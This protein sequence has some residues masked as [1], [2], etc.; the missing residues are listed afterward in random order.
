MRHRRATINESFGAWE[1]LYINSGCPVRGE[2][3]VHFQFYCEDFHSK[4][5]Q[6]RGYAS[7]A[8]KAVLAQGFENG[9]HRAYAE[10]DPR[11][12]CS[13]ALLEKCGFHREALLRQNVWFQKDPSGNPIWQN[14]YVYALLSTDQ[15]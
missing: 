14:T 11:N 8:L 9:L 10:C 3:L 2:E 1:F 6:R 7:E 12:E 15:P 5:Y 4:N 13:W